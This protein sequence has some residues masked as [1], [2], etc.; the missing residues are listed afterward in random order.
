MGVEAVPM[1]RVR[2]DKALETS[3][4]CFMHI[5]R[6]IGNPVECRQ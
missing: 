5:L 2:S 3:L 6:A 4:S 1:W